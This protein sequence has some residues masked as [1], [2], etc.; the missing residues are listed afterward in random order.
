M[1]PRPVALTIS[2]KHG[3]TVTI[4]ATEIVPGLAIHPRVRLDGSLDTDQWVVT[5]I[6]SLMYLGKNQHSR[7]AA[8]ALARSLDGRMDWELDFEA[9]QAA[10]RKLE[11]ERR[12]EIKAMAEAVH[13]AEA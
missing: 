11:P 13:E 5:H 10:W 2:L 1:E 7:A 8:V 9:W 4:D 12:E 6:K 3:G